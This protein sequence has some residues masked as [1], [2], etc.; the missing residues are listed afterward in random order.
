ME[1]LTSLKDKDGKPFSI[2]DRHRCETSCSRMDT[3]TIINGVKK[4][5]VLWTKNGKCP[6]DKRLDVEVTDTGII[7]KLVLDTSINNL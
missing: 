2:V 7:F 5:K 4:E 6:E 3:T 1:R